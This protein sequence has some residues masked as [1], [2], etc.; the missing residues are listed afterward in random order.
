MAVAAI[1]LVPAFRGGMVI[2][3]G[4]VA[5]NEAMPI[6]WQVTTLCLLKCE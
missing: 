6:E 4:I 2:W 3:K 1:F 5:G